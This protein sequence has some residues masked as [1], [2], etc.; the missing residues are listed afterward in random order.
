MTATDRFA[1]PHSMDQ[2]AEIAVKVGLNL[3]EGQDLLITADIAMA[4]M[5]RKVTE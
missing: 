3:Q 2:L 5:V 1:D 4:G